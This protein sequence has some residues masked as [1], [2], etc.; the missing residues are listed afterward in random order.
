MIGKVLC[1]F[2]LLAVI[3][4]AISGNM[5]AVGSA[6]LDGAR[7]A[8][9][10]ALSLTGMMCLW[11][12]LCNVFRDAGVVK[13]LAVL[14]RPLLRFAFPGVAR[15]D[16]GA[17]AITAN[18]SANLLGVGNAATPL[19][20]RAMKEMQ[21]A[22]GGTAD[23]SETASDDMISLVVLNSASISLVPS[24]ILALR[25]QAGSVHPF[26]VVVPIWISSICG[27][28]LSLILL[29]AMQWRRGRREGATRRM[30][31]AVRHGAPTR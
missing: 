25:R 7:S 24:T 17:E 3:F 5:E 19:A 30:S 1:A 15:N 18:L 21:E 9:E 2:C 27:F 10:L 16:A 4:G 22:R 28:F 26:A 29:R 13:R 31:R 11:N 20:L 6:V 23:E 14:F 8:V 12:G